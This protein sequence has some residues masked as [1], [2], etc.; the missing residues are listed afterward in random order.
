MEK[1][2]LRRSA[3]N[4]SYKNNRKCKLVDMKI[5]KFIIPLV[6]TS[7][8]FGANSVSYVPAPTAIDKQAAIEFSDAASIG[9]FENKKGSRLDISYKIIILYDLW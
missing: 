8:V 4:V 5:A 7:S 6:F 3:L 1:I 2:R 9:I